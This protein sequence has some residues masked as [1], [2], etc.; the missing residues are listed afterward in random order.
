MNMGFPGGASGKVRRCKRHG[1]DPW[2]RKISGGGHSSPLQC[3]YLEN[4]MDRGTWRATVYR[5]QGVRYN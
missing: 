1:F 3:F 2:V 4:L 5:S